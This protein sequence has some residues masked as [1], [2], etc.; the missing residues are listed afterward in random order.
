MEKA[1]GMKT[2]ILLVVLLNMAALF[3]AG[4]GQSPETKAALKELY[5]KHPDTDVT[6]DPYYN[7][8]SFA[9]TVWKTKVKVAVAELERYSGVHDIKLLAPDSFDPEHPRYDPPKNLQLNS[10][11]A[12]GTRIRIERLMRDQG[13]W[14]GVQVVATVED[15]TNFQKN[16]YLDPMLLAKN[17][18]VWAG[19]SMST[20]W[21]VNP[22]MLEK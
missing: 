15:S 16:V 6:G 1:E 10:V 19:S 2:P 3:L 9:G 12:A 7:F 4:C 5:K 11:L 21:G 22:D 14:G 20:N 13:V 8:S 17:R 18:F